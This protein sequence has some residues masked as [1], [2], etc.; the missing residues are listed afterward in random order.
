[1]TKQEKIL[2]CPWGHKAKL[3]NSGFTDLNMIYCPT[4]QK[5]SWYVQTKFYDTYKKAV[6]AWNKRAK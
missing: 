4:C 1:M 2:P 5:N 6:K 3:H